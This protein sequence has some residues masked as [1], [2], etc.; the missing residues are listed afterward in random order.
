MKSEHEREPDLD[1]PDQT[2]GQGE[3]R[4]DPTIPPDGDEKPPTIYPDGNAT[5]LEDS[6]A[7]LARED[8]G[9]DR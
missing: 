8:E 3:G 2:W 7:G 9:M 6:D 5:N 4:H 1:P